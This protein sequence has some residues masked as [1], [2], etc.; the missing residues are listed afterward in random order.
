MQLAR[1]SGMQ[2]WEGTERCFD[3]APRA[4][5]VNISTQGWRRGESSQSG[6]SGGIGRGE[7][8]GGGGRRAIE[9]VA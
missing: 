4:Q 8:R 2:G 7:S 3:Y 6:R 1:S 5:S 9:D